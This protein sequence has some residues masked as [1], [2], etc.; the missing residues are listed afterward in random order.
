[1]P[2]CQLADPPRQVFHRS[3]P[4]PDWE[5]SSTWFGVT[6]DGTGGVTALELADNGLSGV[7]PADLG[8]LASLQTLAL[9]SNALTGA[10]PTEFVNLTNLQTLNLSG[11]D[12]SGCVPAALYTV[13]SND[14]GTLPLPSCAEKE[15]LAAL[16]NATDGANWIGSSNWLSDKPLG[17]WSGVSTAAGGC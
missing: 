14:L 4:A 17:E 13:S 10:I 12:L 7:I 11:N 8:D 16:Y 9:Q 15:A 2:P 5:P 1:M 3:E 6:I